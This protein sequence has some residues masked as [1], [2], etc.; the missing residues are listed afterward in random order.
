VGLFWGISPENNTES[1]F[2]GCRGVNTLVKY[3]V[4]RGEL[5]SPSHDTDGFPYLR[6]NVILPSCYSRIRKV[7]KCMDE[8]LGKW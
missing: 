4:R 2:S 6:N 7:F 8:L 5:H 1:G 3:H